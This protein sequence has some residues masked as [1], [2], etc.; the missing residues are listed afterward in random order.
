[1]GKACLFTFIGFSF[2]F[3][4][5]ANS[6]V[7]QHFDVIIDEILADPTPIIGLPNA[8]YIEVKNTSG[9]DVNLQGYRLHSLTTRSGSFP[10][11]IL[12]ADSFLIIS[13]T[14][15]SS[16]FYSYGRAFG[17]SSFP[18]LGNSG[19]TLYL[20]SK[21]GA[22]IHAVSYKNTWFQNDVKSVGGWSLEMIDPL[23]PCSAASNWKASIHPK[24]GTPGSKNSLDAINPDNVAPALVRAVALDSVT[25][26]LSFS[27][28]VDS[29]KAATVANYSI[30]DG[31][32]SP[33]S[34]VTIAPTFS[35]V[36]LKLSIPVRET[37]VYTLTVNSVADCS[38]NVLHA[39]N[40]TRVG[41]ASVIDSSDL[42]INEIL[43]NP[44]PAS[45]D[46]VE[47]YNRSAK[48]FN[49]KDVYIANRSFGTNAL[50][51]LQRVTSED[52]L[53]FPS[54]FLLLS[55]DGSIVKQHY[56]SKNEENFIDVTMPSL[57]DDEG[58]FVLLNAQGKVADEI[59]YN[60]KWHFPL[61]D[62]DEGISLERIDYHKPTQNKDNWTSAASTAGF[63]TPSYQ[64]SQ[65]RADVLLQGEV[66]ITPRTFSPDNDGYEDYTI[67][68]VKTSELGFVANITIFNASGRP[69]KGLAKN[70]TLAQTASFRWDGLDDKSQKV[71]IGVYVVFTEVFNL[72][73]KKKSF[74]NSVVV[75][76]R[77]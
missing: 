11:Y 2:L 76:H 49:L 58:V 65:F 30:S 17:I 73:G 4:F 6:Q 34:A 36:K 22:T 19:T 15:N 68:N 14:A 48:I 28:P 66:S 55:E 24:G 35:Q 63:G 39:L 69:V 8:E 13:S 52:I 21:D 20:T 62:N 10:S 46:Y 5:K 45:I 60:S 12:P 54:D 59:H 7:A 31:V 44:K 64:N 37:K 77:F 71:P 72:N 74:R 33:V 26:V 32:G 18:A 51:N 9:R 57:P 1:M 75:A 41:L 50:S 3:Y 29:A 70:A 61:I 27:E 47:I 40:T 43:F 42:I 16:L 38:G 23:N 67:I 53:F 56:V 25:I